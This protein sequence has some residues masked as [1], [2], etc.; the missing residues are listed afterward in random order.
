[1]IFNPV[2]I[3]FLCE[4]I[5]KLL[6]TSHTGIINIAGQNSLTKYDFIK[7][8]FKAARADLKY[9]QKGEYGAGAV[10]QTPRPN[11]M[12]LSPTLFQ[13]I[14]GSNFPSYEDMIKVEMMLKSSNA[15]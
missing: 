3:T 15:N 2:S 5:D 14:T 1:M 12:A 13:S 10:N 8:I 9:L 11:F 6:Q 4:G 7:L